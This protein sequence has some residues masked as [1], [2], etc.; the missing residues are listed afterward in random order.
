[1]YIRKR[2]LFVW[3]FL[4]GTIGLWAQGPAGDRIKTLKV[5]FITEQ[6]SLTPEEAQAFWPLYNQYE[7]QREAFRRKEHLELKAQRESVEA[8]T[9]KEASAL[10][11]EFLSLQKEKYEA[12]RDFIAK[13]SKIITPQKTLLLLEAEKTFKKQL[14]HQYRKRGGG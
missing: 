2:H 12:E 5:G 14:L 7:A 3:A 1:M 6:L 9:R 8:P 13:I 10:L 4:V 11:D